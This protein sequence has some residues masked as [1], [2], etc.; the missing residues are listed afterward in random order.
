MD[1]HTCALCGTTG[2]V[3][4]PGTFS[5]IL[6]HPLH[7]FC[8]QLVQA[9]HSCDHLPVMPFWRYGFSQWQ[10]ITQLYRL[11]WLGSA[12]V[13]AICP[14]SVGG[15]ACDSAPGMYRYTVVEILTLVQAVILQL[16]GR[17]TCLYARVV[18]CKQGRRRCVTEM[19]AAQEDLF[20]C[21]VGFGVAARE[22]ACSVWATRPLVTPARCRSNR[23][24]SGAVLLWQQ[25]HKCMVQRHARLLVNGA[26]TGQMVSARVTV[27]KEEWLMQP[28]AKATSC[29][30]CSRCQ[31]LKA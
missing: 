3:S 6:P 7:A 12:E 20:G 29:A 13:G 8:V 14:T 16:R 9:N 28:I 1:N 19:G 27:D 23:C 25:Q 10:Q 11:L 17:V 5:I 31:G 21:H 18:D 30:M 2:D 22:V 26:A 15:G 24:P 4:D